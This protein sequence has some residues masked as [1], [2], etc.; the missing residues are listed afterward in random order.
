MRKKIALLL[1]GVLAAGVIA[2]CSGNGQAGDAGGKTDK[3]GVADDMKEKLTITFM[4]E[5][6]G[7][8][9]WRE[10]HPTVK[11][12]NEKFNIEMKIMWTDGPTYK[13]KLNVFAASGDL[14]DMYRVTSDNFV[15]W[16]NEGVFMDLAPHLDKYPN[17]AKA[18]PDDQWKML[19]PQ[20]KLYG[21]PA[22]GLEIRDSYQIRADWIRN[23]G[24]TMPNEETFNVDEFY[25]I[26][27]AFA[28]ND[29][30]K[31][32]KKDTAGFATDQELGANTAQLRA[33]FG[34]ANG[35]KL[36]DGKLIPQNVQSKEQK[37]FLGYLHKMYEEG[38]MD[39]D[40]L[41]KKGIN[42]YELFQGGKS[43]IWTHHP[44]GLRTDTEKLKS[45]DPNAELV[46]LAPPIG[47]TGLR[48][49]PTGLVGA[50]KA[51]INGKID[52]KKQQRL[53]E[54]LDWWMT[55][56]GTDIMR[57]GIEGVHYTKEA[58][59]TYKQTP[60]GDT[61]LPRIMNNWFFWR[62]DPEFFVHKWT[63]PAIAEFDRKYNENNAKYPWK[64]DSAGL[65]IYSETYQK[66]WKD[67]ETKFKE[68]Q[69][70]IVVGQEPV[71]S[72]DKAIA[73][74]KAGGG[75]KII[76][77]MNDAYAKYKS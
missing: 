52:P 60:L 23:V 41:S 57:N 76:Q 65:E 40:F 20:G 8:G 10:D 3:A 2:G 24:L 39:K 9:K 55:D 70:K 42:V 34:L 36:V 72:I 43:G 51:V 27:K 64:N 47:P 67:L 58:N 50:N 56:E 53:L 32:G 29:P 49:N 37:D 68:A 63:E 21:M 28:L 38:V 30:D 33:A 26:M 48:G 59:G 6:W 5:S 18:F 35:W 14:P 17:L 13:D 19:N 77:E 61:D 15:K 22:W 62:A 54:L 1:T 73:D 4:P 11:Y 75:D 66:L 25:Q 31:N 7:G 71:D 45:I 46:Q 16:Q 74:W 69:L 12:L 44:L